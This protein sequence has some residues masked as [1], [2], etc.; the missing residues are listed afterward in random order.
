MTKVISLDKKLK[1]VRDEKQALIRKRKVQAVQK[2]F[3]CTHCAFKCE[4]CG[5]QIE[6]ADAKGGR[7]H[8]KSPYRFCQGCLEE[9]LE[10]IEKLKG[11][12]NPD[13]YWHN[14]AWMDLWRTWIDYQS[15]LD[16]Y[17]RSKEFVRLM[18]DLKE[19][20]PEE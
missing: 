3:Q 10:Y 18:Q 17:L 2:V 13:C 15:S 5:T 7:G 16:R 12:E 20:G 11:R 4:K 1:T 8:P 6:P 14:S 19:N 9:Y